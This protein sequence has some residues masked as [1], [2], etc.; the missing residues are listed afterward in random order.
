[1]NS[2]GRRDFRIL[3]GGEE[4]FRCKLELF[5]GAGCGHFLGRQCGDFRKTGKKQQNAKVTKN[6]TSC[7]GC[8]GRRA[9]MQGGGGESSDLGAL[10]SQPATQVPSKK[11]TRKKGLSSGSLGREK[12]L[13][14]RFPKKGSWDAAI[15]ELISLKK[16]GIC[17]CLCVWIPAFCETIRDLVPPL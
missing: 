13:I 8:L 11:R 1:M 4:R 2:L 15:W 9:G 16:G 5:G 3:L 7:F 14:L 6:K 10:K 17:I 12:S